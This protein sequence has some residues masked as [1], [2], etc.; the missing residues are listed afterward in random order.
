MVSYTKE[1]DI[2]K[3]E[4]KRLGEL[5]KEWKVQTIESSPRLSAWCKLNDKKPEDVDFLE[6]LEKC[7]LMKLALRVPKPCHLSTEVPSSAG[8]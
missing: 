6:E 1:N 7:Y 8:V 3:E 4:D 5:V 2:G